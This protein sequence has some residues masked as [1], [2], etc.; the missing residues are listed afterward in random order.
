MEHNFSIG[1]RIRE[2][3]TQNYLS[4]EQLALAAE[5]TTAYLGQIERNEKN[6]TVSVVEKICRALEIGLA[7]F[8]LKKNYRKK[9]WIQ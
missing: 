8:F 1:Q 2:L 9:K 6:P 7:E 3:R 5:I 4:Q